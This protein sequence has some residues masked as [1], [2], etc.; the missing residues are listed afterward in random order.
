M[1]LGATTFIS[2]RWGNFAMSRSVETWFSYSL[3]PLGFAM[4][5]AHDRFHFLTSFGTVIPVVQRFAADRGLGFFSEPAWACA[6][7]GPVADWLP[8][9]EIVYLGLG[10]L[11]SLLIGH[12]IAV[13]LTGR[14]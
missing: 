13:R 11:M 2:H 9:L 14:P 4:W 5:L 8:R 3:V 6:C 1:I 7:C 12:R 10:W